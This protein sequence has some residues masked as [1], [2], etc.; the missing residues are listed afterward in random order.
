[1]MSFYTIML[2][3]YCM[4]LTTKGLWLIDGAKVFTIPPLLIQTISLMNLPPPSNNNLCVC[5][6][7]IMLTYYCMD[8]TYTQGTLAPR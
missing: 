5:L 3:Y 8:L 7:T 6:F 1:M 4:D 2:K